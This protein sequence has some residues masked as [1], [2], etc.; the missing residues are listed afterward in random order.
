MKMKKRNL[1][2]AALVIAL[3]AAVYLNWQF[4]GDNT[5]LTSST[6]ELGAAEYVNNDTT[7]T[8]PS[9]TKLSSKQSN[10]FADARTKRE[11]S[12]DKVVDIAKEVLEKSDSST[13]SKESAK[14]QAEK[15]EKY[16]TYQTNIENLLKAKGFT[17]CLCC[18]TEKGCSV[19]VGLVIIDF[20]CVCKGITEGDETVCSSYKNGSRSSAADAAY[21]VVVLLL[22]RQSVPLADK[23]DT[24]VCRLIN[25]CQSASVGTYP[26]A[27]GAVGYDVEYLVEWQRG[28]IVRVIGKVPYLHLVYQINTVTVGSNPCSSLDIEVDGV[29]A[30]FGEVYLLWH[31]LSAWRKVSDTLVGGVE[32]LDYSIV[33]ACPDMSV[34]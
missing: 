17:D 8:S 29:D 11:Q 16:I 15:I 18:I 24:A 2:V 27:S 9:K 25:E 13:D 34:W 23:A 12:Q 33:I 4:G 32:Y 6:K 31:N 19:V 26:D 10:Y 1:I 21:A 7:V 22:P 20:P 5:L 14:A 3:G 28:R 30:R